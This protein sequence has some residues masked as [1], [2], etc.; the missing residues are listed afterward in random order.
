MAKYTEFYKGRRKR[1]NYIFI[2]AAIL[3]GILTFG[4]VMF[5]G[6]QKYAVIYMMF[7][8]S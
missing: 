4:V 1:R 2:P 6:V 7:G 3:I 5:Y 8:I